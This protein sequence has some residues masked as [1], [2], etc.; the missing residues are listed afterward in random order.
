MV[1]P[2]K[3]RVLGTQFTASSSAS[4][5]TSGNNGCGN[6]NNG[7][8]DCTPPGKAIT[9]TGSVIGEV[10][11]GKAATLR[12]VIQNPNNQDMTL[13]SASATVGAPSNANCLASWFSVTPY[14][15]SPAVTV[16]KTNSVTLDL[17]FNMINKPFNQDACKSAN[18]P[19]RFTATAVGA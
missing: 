18:I 1:T 8:K 3:T 19:L 9:V 4:S 17:V 5:N 12:L 7:S 6:S 14:N 11:P 13:Q 10:A 15:G 16:K 2:G